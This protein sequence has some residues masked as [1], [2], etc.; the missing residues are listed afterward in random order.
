MSLYQ[1]ALL[2]GGPRH[3][4]STKQGDT[5]M[6]KLDKTTIAERD[7]LEIRLREEQE[8]LQSAIN[9]YNDKMSEAWAKVSAA[10]DEYNSALDDA[11]GGANGLEQDISAY[12]DAIGS[13]NEWKQ[14]VAQEIQDYMDERSEKWQESEAAGRYSSWKDE[15]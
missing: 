5:C 1:D 2:S 13:C 11:W 6:K 15:Y 12:N 9:F 14:G 4:N 7:T 10:I 3:T 8:D